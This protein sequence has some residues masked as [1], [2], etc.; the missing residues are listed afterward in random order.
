[1]SMCSQYFFP[2]N[3]TITFLF[4]PSLR[5]VDMRTNHIAVLPSPGLWLS[6]N[7]HELMFSHNII[8]ELDLSGPIHN[9]SRLEKLHLSN[10]KLTEVS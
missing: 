3:E 6:S 10:N 7:L 5:S 4:T 9:W 2:C 1:M 8:H